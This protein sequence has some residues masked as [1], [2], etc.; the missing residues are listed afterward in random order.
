MSISKRVADRL[1]GIRYRF[2]AQPVRR[3]PAALAEEM[4]ASGWRWKKF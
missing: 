3:F 1:C 2:E 4:K